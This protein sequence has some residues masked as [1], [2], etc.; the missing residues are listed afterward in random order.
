[1]II[2]KLGRTLPKADSKFWWV[3]RHLSCFRC[4]E[5]VIL[6]V[7]DGEI[8]P[9]VEPPMSTTAYLRVPCTNCGEVTDH[10]V[11]GRLEYIERISGRG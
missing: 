2:V 7:E 9:F 4:D 6:S 5:T 1:M 3:G 11:E 8:T 10:S